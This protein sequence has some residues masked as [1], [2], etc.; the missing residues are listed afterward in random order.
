MRIEAVA[1][2]FRLALPEKREAKRIK[3]RNLSEPQA[4]LF[5]FPL[6]LGFFREPEGQR[7]AV[8]FFAFFF[9][10][11]KKKVARRGQSRLVPSE[12]GRRCITGDTP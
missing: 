10:E 7:L 9:G 12:R 3:K 4:S 5:R 8:A 1:V 2:E 11:T 6:C